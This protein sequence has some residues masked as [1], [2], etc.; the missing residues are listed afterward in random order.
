MD[1]FQRPHY[2][3][4]ARRIEGNRVAASRNRPQNRRSL[5]TLMC[6]VLIF[7]FFLEVWADWNRHR[8]DSQAWPLRRYTPEAARRS[9]RDHEQRQRNCYFVCHSLTFSSGDRFAIQPSNRVARRQSRALRFSPIALVIVLVWGIL[10]GFSDCSE[11]SALC[12]RCCLRCWRANCSA[13]EKARGELC[14]AA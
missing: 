5:V 1:I 2:F 11:N 12:S 3:V 8:Q 10:A 4:V 14:L 13:H 6:P 9:Q 7:L